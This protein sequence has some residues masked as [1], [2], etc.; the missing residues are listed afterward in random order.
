MAQTNK[1]QLKLMQLLQTTPTGLAN[2]Y[3]KQTHHLEISMTKML[4]VIW[5]IR[6][7]SLFLTSQKKLMSMIKHPFEQKQR[8]SGH[9]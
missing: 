4:S 1:D 2:W 3:N 6:Y 5:G 8:P 9:I 7:A